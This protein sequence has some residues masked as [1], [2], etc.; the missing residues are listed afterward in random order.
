MQGNTHHGNN[1]HHQFQKQQVDKKSQ[2]KSINTTLKK[3][4]QNT[5]AFLIHL[6]NF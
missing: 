2:D 5:N 3:I 4:I 6:N 1:L